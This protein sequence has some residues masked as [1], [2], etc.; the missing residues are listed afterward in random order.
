VLKKM[1]RRLSESRSNFF[2]QNKNKTSIRC[3]FFT[4]FDLDCL[5]DKFYEA[6]LCPKTFRTIFSPWFSY[7]FLTWIFRQIFIEK[8]Q[9]KVYSNILDKLLGFMA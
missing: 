8:Q 9:T 6:V 2:G 7:K 3:H 1:R 4:S 5:W